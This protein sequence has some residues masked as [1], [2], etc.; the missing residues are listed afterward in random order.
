MPRPD[1]IDDQAGIPDETLLWRGVP[2]DQIRPDGGPN[3][4]AF[5]TQELSVSI[6]NKT[7]PAAVIAKGK[8]RGV[9]WRLWE[10]T[11][12]A[13]RGAGCIVDRDPTPDD[14]AHAVVLR[15]DAPGKRISEGAAKKLVRSGRWIG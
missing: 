10:F 14:P 9:D 1:W 7:T 12:G 8:Q 11:A 6:G 15:A 3:I 5:I 2:P 4:A 13:A